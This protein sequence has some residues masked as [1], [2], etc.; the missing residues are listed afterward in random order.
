MTDTVF[1]HLTLEPFLGFIGLLIAVKIIGKRQV[2]QVSPFDFVSAVVLGELLS[3]ALYNSE[4]TII[5]IFY[6]ISVC[7]YA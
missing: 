2:Q 6:A 3:N 5:H 4:T 1:I 7:Y